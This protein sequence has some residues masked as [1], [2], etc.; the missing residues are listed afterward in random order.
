MRIGAT[1]RY[2]II[3][4]NEN[5]AAGQQIRQDDFFQKQP[6]D[7]STAEEVFEGILLTAQRE[8]QEKKLKFYG[9]L[10]ANIAFRVDIDRDLANALIRQVESMSYRQIC[11]LSLSI[12]KGEFSTSAK[13]GWLSLNSDN[14][15]ESSLQADVTNLHQQYILSSAQGSQGS[16][17]ELNASMLGKLLIDLMELRDIDRAD[18]EKIAAFLI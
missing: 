13:G 12:R 18:L 9:N 11:I 2:G 1:L 15:I 8:Y 17:G 6:D 7:R 14:V 3:K 5:M 4:I 16:E 10:L